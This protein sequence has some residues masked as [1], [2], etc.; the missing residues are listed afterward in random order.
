MSA[1]GCPGT[2]G[3]GPPNSSEREHL[4][5]II[6][7]LPAGALVTADAGF[8]GY[9]YGKELRDGGRHL[10]IRRSGRRTC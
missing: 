3:S 6:V 4:K 2:G 7:A 1:P 10:L 8:V 9:E 5:Q